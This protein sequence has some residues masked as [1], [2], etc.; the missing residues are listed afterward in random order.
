[1]RMFFDDLLKI[2]R[3][4]GTAPNRNYVATAT[5][6]GVIQP[7]GK[8][9][10]QFDAEQFGST[11]VAYVDVATPVNESDRVT[12]HNSVVYTVQQ[13]VVRDVGMLQYKELILKRN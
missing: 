11:Y 9:R 13:V 12:D 10:G 4:K 8:E 3:L 5:A 7:L 2:K 6:D 1:M